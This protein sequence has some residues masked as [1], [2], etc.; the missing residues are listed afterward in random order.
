MAKLRLVPKVFRERYPPI[1]VSRPSRPFG[2]DMT[3]RPA[4]RV[5]GPPI[6]SWLP[7][8]TYLCLATGILAFEVVAELSPHNSLIYVDIVEQTSRRIIS[9]RTFAILLM[10]SAVATTLRTSMRGVRIRGDGIEYRDVV[11]F[12]LP[13][14]RRFRWAQMDCIRL[15]DPKDISVELWD[16][17]RAYLPAVRDPGALRAAL[18]KVAV[19]RGILVRGGSG[20][21]EI[22]EADELEES[23]A[24]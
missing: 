12:L 9:A 17:T 7:A 1:I 10:I 3:Y 22:L 24:T 15:D 2:F 18:E 16:G 6:R 4:E 11:S 5:F 23:S 8:L 21:D 13:K 14:M 20:L 19:K